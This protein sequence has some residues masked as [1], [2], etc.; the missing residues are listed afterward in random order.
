MHHSRSAR[1][2]IA[3]LACAASTAISAC[4]GSMRAIPALPLESVSSTTRSVPPAVRP[5][6][7]TGLGKVLT[8]SNSGQIFGFAVGQDD[9]AGILAT[10]GHV[11]TFDQQ[12]GAITGSFPKV[13]PRG[14]S[15][16][17]DGIFAGDLALVT[18]YFV[19]KGTIYAT[20][21]YETVSP[22]TAGKF[23]G[24]WTPPVKDIDVQQAGQDPKSTTSVLFA[25]ELKNNDIPDLFSSDIAANTFG[26]VIHLDPNHFSLGDQPQLATFVIG[27]K[28]VLAT[29]PDAGTVGGEAPINVLVDIKTGATTQFNGYN[30]GGFGAGF[31]NGMALDPNTGIEATTTELNAQVEFY[32]VRK[33]VGTADV[34][35]PCSGNTDQGNSGAGVAVDTVHKLFLVTDPAY[36][37]DNSQDGAIVVYDEKGTVVEVI[38]PFKFAIAEPAPAIDVSKRLGWAFGPQ[39]DQLQQFFY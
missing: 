18:R 5:D 30:S 35:L 33:H 21:Y 27:G 15:Y 25:I 6:H 26:K 39:F 13:T 23:T 2:F 34:Q 4:S 1:H 10:A 17:L 11:Q 8:T 19:P 20:R 37:C 38:H 36:A 31:V 24:K 3:A 22:F 28:A 9:E 12:T 32:D 16:G 29:S 7:R 14:T